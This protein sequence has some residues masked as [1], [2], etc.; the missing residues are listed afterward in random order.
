MPDDPIV[1]VTR[2]SEK[3]LVTIPL[4][5][6]EAKHKIGDKSVLSSRKRRNS[7]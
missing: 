3:G 6:R 7:A 4:E 1:A 2:V 5:I